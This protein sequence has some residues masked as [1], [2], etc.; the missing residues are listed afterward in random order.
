[1]QYSG[2]NKMRQKIFLIFPLIILCMVH[3]AK[4]QI[5]ISSGV[6][7]NSA[8]V[9]VANL[10]TKILEKYRA[11]KIAPDFINIL[12]ALNVS[13]RFSIKSGFYTHSEYFK[14]TT[15]HNFYTGN[16]KIHKY[17]VES[18]SRNIHWNSPFHF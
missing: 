11:T 15:Y 4:C 9:E 3:S 2:I 14:Y 12:V 1:M 10:N 13:S 6:S 7:I 18:I 5:Y 17:T 16:P 8:S